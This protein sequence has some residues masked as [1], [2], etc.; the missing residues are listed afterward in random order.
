MEKKYRRDIDTLKGIAIISVV[1]YHLGFLKSGYLGVDLFFAI[2]G[3]FIIPKLVNKVSEGSFGINEFIKTRLLRLYPLVLLG[4]IVT[5][6]LGY[7]LMLPNTYANT[8][9]SV[10]A[11]LAMSNNIVEAITTK[12][13]WDIVNEYKPLMHL[14]Y[15]GI[16]FEFYIVVPLYLL[17]IKRLFRNSKIDT[18]KILYGSLI[19]LLLGSFMLY[20]CPLYSNSQK[21]Y[22]LPFRLWELLLGG[23]VPVLFSKQKASNILYWGGDFN[24]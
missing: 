16:L 6:I 23:C 12:N 15:V 11:S 4:C 13:Y 20:V 3:F 17:I 19:I 18:Y 7:F 14:W 1:L 24:S 2:N 5:M 8:S 10:I 21:F 22:Y 9:K